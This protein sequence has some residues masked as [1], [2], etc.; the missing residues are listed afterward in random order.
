MDFDLSVSLLPPHYYHLLG[1]PVFRY[2]HSNRLQVEVTSSISF[3]TSGSQVCLILQ[4]L[5]RLGYQIPET[6][7][8]TNAFMKRTFK[9]ETSRRRKAESEDAQNFQRTVFMVFTH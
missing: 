4:L 7:S 8:N 6:T 9:K 2:Q 3:P 5:F 1:H